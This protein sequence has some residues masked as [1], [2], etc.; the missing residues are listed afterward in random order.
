MKFCPFTSVNEISFNSSKDEIIQ[1][2]GNPED[3]STN[4]RG[5]YELVYGQS[6]YR[7]DKEGRLVEVTANLE[8]IEINGTTVQYHLLK[9]FLYKYDSETF[10]TVGFIV[11]PKFGIAFDPAQKFWITHFRQTELE[12][13]RN[14]SS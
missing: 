4:S 7:L 6:V 13:W 3:V 10:D 11:S 9:D 5:W 1:E 12:G 14:V 2:F 8:S